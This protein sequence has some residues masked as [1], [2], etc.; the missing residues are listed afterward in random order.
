MKPRIKIYSR[1][2][3]C[4]R[5]V[6]Q[7]EKNNQYHCAFG[8]TEEISFQKWKDTEPKALSEKDLE[9]DFPF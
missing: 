7:G 8:E 4:I 6:C 9:D 3:A 2:T 5:F 1:D